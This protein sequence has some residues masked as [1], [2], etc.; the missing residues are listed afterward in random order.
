MLKDILKDC[1]AV[2]GVGENVAN[3]A[4]MV[5]TATFQLPHSREQESEADVI[6][7]ELMARSGYE[8]EAAVNVWKKMIA[9]QQS[10]G[11]P[12]FLSTHPN[13]ES[14]IRDLQALVP[15][16]GAVAHYR[17]G[18]RTNSGP[19]LGPDDWCGLA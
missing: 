13:P 14:R 4:N 3:V 9:A 16:R 8:P 11:G 12:E 15:G 17:L 7:M 19:G 2:T 6:G 5:A 1:A 10:G 18:E